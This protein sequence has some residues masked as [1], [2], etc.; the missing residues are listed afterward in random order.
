SL[1]PP[2]R[3]QEVRVPLL[4]NEDCE[5]LIRQSV[6]D[7]S[8]HKIVLNDMI[9]A[10]SEERRFGKMLWVLLLTLPFL[11][12]SVPVTPGPTPETELVGIVGGRDAPPGKWP[13]QVGLW[14]RN[15]NNHML[16]FKCGG[17]LIHRQWVL[18]AA[19]CVKRM[20]LEP[21]NIEVRLGQV[22]RSWIAVHRKVTE[23]I[24]HRNYNP[25]LEA[26]GGGDVALLKLAAP[27]RLSNQ[28]RVVNLSSPQLWVPAGTRCWVTGWGN[29]RFHVPLP[30]SHH[31]Q[32]VEVPIMEDAVC[33][34]KY[35]K[36]NMIVKEDMLCAG[37]RGRGVCYGD[38][39][40]PLVCNCMGNWLQV[41]VVSWG[42]PCCHPKFPGVYAQ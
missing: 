8:D 33:R 5:Q 34:W 35:W 14:I 13:W 40:G 21:W 39:G 15:P 16:E 18:T 6:P 19:H 32:E 9:C 11:G 42:Q 1:P 2:Y 38:S 27:V 17:S 22:K 36:I 12:S 30:A 20:V 4:S 37:S 26:P 41:G 25:M 24:V 29:I 23:V 3:L 28:I 7:L 10:G 31:L